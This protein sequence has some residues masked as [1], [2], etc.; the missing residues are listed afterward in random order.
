MAAGGGIMGSNNGSMLV[1]P[2]ADGSRPGYGWIDDILGAAK[3]VG[4]TI[5]PGG[6]TGYFDLYGGLM[7]GQTYPGQEGTSSNPIVDIGTN[8]AT[9]FLSN[10]LGGNQNDNL[11]SGILSNYGLDD[12]ILQNQ[13]E[14]TGPV[15][16][17]DMNLSPLSY[18]KPYLKQVTKSATKDRVVDDPNNPG[19][20][21]VIPGTAEESKRSVNPVYPI[22]AGLGVG[23]YVSGLPKDTLPMDTTSMN[24]A[25]IATAA[26]GTDAQ[27]AA[28]G[29]RFLPEQVTRAAEGGR[30]G[31]R[32]GIG[33]NQASPRIMSQ[34]ITDTEVE[35]A[36]G[37]TVDQERA[38]TDQEVEDAFGISVDDAAPVD[39]K[40]LKD[41]FRR[42]TKPREMAK[43]KNLLGKVGEEEAAIPPLGK[44]GEEEAAT[45]LNDQSKFQNLML[46][47]QMFKAQGMNAND[48]LKAAQAHFGSEGFGR[49]EG[50][51][52]GYQN[53]G[54]VLPEGLKAILERIRKMRSPEEFRLSPE[55][56]EG[57][58][59]YPGRGGQ[60]VPHEREPAQ[61]GGLM[62][63]GG[64]EKDYRQEGGF[65]PIGGKEKAD[66]VPARLSK[67]EFV[68]TADAVRNAGA[69]DIDKGA[70]VMENMMNYLE[71]G[72]EVSEDSQGLEGARGMFANAQK[73]EKR[74]I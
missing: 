48:A 28:A 29:L 4:Q 38:I 70:E 18:L 54:E 49:A 33:P 6:E 74:I 60:G 42:L 11:L 14:P 22:T 45:P 35:D 10:Y 26:R 64:M 51:R 25:A 66:D 21:I 59:R 43:Y 57:G 8:V 5:M 24:P 12:F 65:V 63:L 39:I 17:P 31:Y 2:T 68:F 58:W 71:A 44:M 56:I 67:N 30:I 50:G 34:A 55:M 27:G 7:P 1:A 52:I 16:D 40:K 61:E 53:A 20:K 41:L 9:N 15:I 32:D 47:V 23:K 46:L 73:L 3:K 69:G 19:K 13:D 36:F 37:M 62:N 72:G